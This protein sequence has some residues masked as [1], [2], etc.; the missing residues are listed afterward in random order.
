MPRFL[1]DGSYAGLTGVAV[2]VTDRKQA[3]EER[4][5]LLAYEREQV[6]RLR[7]LDG[8][9]DDLVATV[10]HELRTPL[11]NIL[12]YVN[13]A[14]GV[15][16]E[17]EGRRLLSVIE[18][19]A[20]RLLNLVNDLLVVAQVDS[21]KLTIQNEPVDFPALVRESVENARAAA[22]LKGLT[23]RLEAE[24]V[25]GFRGDHPRLVQLVDNLLGNAIKF[26]ASGGH[27]T[28]RVGAHAGTAFVEVEDSGIGIAEKDLD[29]L[30]ERFYRA[31]EARQE[32]VQGT[33]LGLDDR[34]RDR[35]GPRRHRHSAQRSE[36][37][38]DLPGR[39]SG[40]GLGARSGV[41]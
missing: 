30:F 37:R 27:V 10:S 24:P 35:R 29:R 31:A 7:E 41:K 16:S 3:E 23:L 38:R 5:R 36:R 18:R 28:V 6:E 17:G 1:P 21:G 4:E 26:T 12:G 32:A 14:V 33:G 34:P 20:K 22:Q 40:A 9:K 11:T 19:N 2:D 15:I 8:L 39:A 25:A 13:V